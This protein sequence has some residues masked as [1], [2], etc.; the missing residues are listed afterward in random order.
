VNFATATPDQRAG[1]LSELG[2]MCAFLESA[3]DGLSV[4]ETLAPGPD[5][6]FSPVEQCWH[7]ADLEREGFGERIRR[8]LVEEDPA[9]P[10]FDGARIALERDYRSRP[11]A[12]GLVAF[13]AARM[14]NLETLRRVLEAGW[15]RAGSLAGVGPVTLGDVPRM[16]A[17]HDAEHRLQILAWIRAIRTSPAGGEVGG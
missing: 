17:E 14:A 5:D 11:L 3:F 8:L 16:M 12:E 10:D 1:F 6:L 15:T 4:A 2:A 7:L 13:R 9:L